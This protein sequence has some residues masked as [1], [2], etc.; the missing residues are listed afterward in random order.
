M[1]EALIITSISGYVE[2]K[3]RHLSWLYKVTYVPHAGNCP[4][5]TEPLIWANLGSLNAN[6]QE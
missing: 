5:A 3:S 6:V 2:G 1:K 4:I